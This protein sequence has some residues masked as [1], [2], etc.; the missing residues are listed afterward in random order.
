MGTANLGTGTKL[1]ALALGLAAF[2]AAALADDPN[3]PGM[4]TNAAIA[5]DKELIRQMNLD[6]LAQVKARDADYAQGWADYARAKNNAQYSTDA[7][8]QKLAAYN[9][10]MAAYNEDQA[11]YA[12]D[13]SNYEQAM[14][15]WRADVTA[16]RAGDR[17]SCE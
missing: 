6:M 15:D 12:Q 8:E 7:Y 13:R 17:S 10:K 11:R 2:P 4:Q 5:A 1:M 9:A 14:V 16:C 3:D